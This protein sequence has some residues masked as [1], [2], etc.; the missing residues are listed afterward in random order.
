MFAISATVVAAPR[1]EPRAGTGKGRRS[2][3]GRKT[4]TDVRRNES[5]VRA[6]ERSRQ[7]SA[8]QVTRSDTSVSQQRDLKQIDF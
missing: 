3:G 4:R 2:F 7:L 1:Q 5:N 6:W 8:R